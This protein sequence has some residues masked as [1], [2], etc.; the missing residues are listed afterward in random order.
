MDEIRN[1]ENGRLSS[2]DNLNDRQDV[3]DP[4]MVD[5]EAGGTDSEKS[6]SRDTAVGEDLNAFG[7][8]ESPRPPRLVDFE[9]VGIKSPSDR[10]EGYAPTASTDRVPGASTFTDPERAPLSGW[11]HRLPEGCTLPS[12]LGVH[13]DGADVGGSAPWG[14][15]TIYPKE[16]MTFEEFRNKFN[17]IEG[18]KL[19]G[20][21]R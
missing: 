3:G 13:A 2:A 4:D 16:S 14:H 1:V 19:E 7:N 18:W 6:A 20:R 9:E 11:Y 17:E 15:R 8:K 21:N 10:I 5:G 12:G